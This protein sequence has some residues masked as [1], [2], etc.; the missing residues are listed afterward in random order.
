VRLV[1]I[2]G[3]QRLG[4]RIEAA[5]AEAKVKRLSGDRR[6]AHEVVLSILAIDDEHAE[7]R[8]LLT[9]LELALQPPAPK[10]STGPLAVSAWPT[11]VAPAETLKPL[12]D[13]RPVADRPAPPKPAVRAPSRGLSRT[14]LGAIV[15]TVA[16]AVAAAVLL[17]RSPV[18]GINP[19]VPLTASPSPQ[20]TTR[21]NVT[22][23][24]AE[25]PPSL[26]APPMAT[27]VDPE[28][29]RKVETFLA[30]GDYA[31]AERAV[32][33]GLRAHPSEPSLR[34]LQQRVQA[35]VQR[36]AD[37][38]RASVETRAAAEKAGAAEAHAK[39]RAESARAAFE[40]ARARAAEAGGER[41]A[42][43]LFTEATARAAR[44]EAAWQR[45]EFDASAGEFDGAA[46][47]M[48]QA[49]R[50]ASEAPATSPP[51]TPPTANRSEADREAILAVIKRYTAA[52]EARDLA[53]VKAVWPSLGG[54]Q[55]SRIQSAFKFAKSLRVLLEVTDVQLGNGTAVVSCRRRDTIVTTEGQTAQ[56]S[57][58]AVIRLAKT[59]GWSI[60]AIQ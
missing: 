25:A 50:A 29:S 16:V 38:A 49:R 2:A 51:V 46:T 60:E 56:N 43:Q 41:L 12:P 15:L 24:V 47:T 23:A 26:V 34:A 21:T 37:E 7:A 53:A 22:D 30:R 4:A 6:G 36:A 45:R 27:L 54:A 14:H 9:E 32:D 42:T 28:I 10:P 5:L 44:A 52:M 3:D 59:D 1:D 13:P 11:A 55:E 33:E 35:E 48:E 8:L 39:A 20:S 58:L 18:S 40:Q 31:A 19:V 17:M 57:Q